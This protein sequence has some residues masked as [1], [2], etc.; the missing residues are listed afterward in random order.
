MMSTLS[1]HTCHTYIRKN[2]PDVEVQISKISSASLLPSSPMKLKHLESALQEVVL[3][4][5]LARQAE[6]EGS[7]AHTPNQDL[8]QYS[9]SP[10]LAARMVYSAAMEHGDIEDM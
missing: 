8:E 9:T 2:C 3:Y 5:H 1:C 10:H 7:S 6:S 4:S